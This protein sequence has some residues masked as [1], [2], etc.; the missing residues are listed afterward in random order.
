MQTCCINAVVTTHE[1]VTKNLGQNS[2][3][4][5]SLICMELSTVG[6]VVP[7]V[8]VGAAHFQSVPAMAHTARPDLSPPYTTRSSAIVNML[9]PCRSSTQSLSVLQC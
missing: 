7:P 8:I 6:E 1:A 4:E 2:I 5:A 9:R 3:T